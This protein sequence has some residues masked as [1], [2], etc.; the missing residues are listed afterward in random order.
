MS[1]TED[2]S[3]K[4]EEPTDK[5]IRDARKKGDV[6]S[7]KETGNLMSIFSLFVVTALIL[8]AAA[9]QLA[10]ALS[11]VIESAGR[12]EIGEAG[13]GLDEAGRVMRGLGLPLAMI[14]APAFAVMVALAIF[15][16]LI[17]GEVVV[18]GERIK[19]NLSKINPLSGLKKLFSKDTLVEF[20]KNLA[21]VAVVGIIG[22]WIARDAVTAIW[23]G[24]LFAPEALPGYLQH[25]VS[26]VLIGASAFLVPLAIVDIV[27][28]RYQWRE[29]LKMSLK[30]VRDE[31]KDSEGDPLIKRKRDEVRRR[32]ARQRV[33]QAVPTASV[34]LTNPT[35]FAVA[36]RYEA[37]RDA[38]PVCV[39]K[40]TDLVAAQIRKLARENDVPLIENRPLARALHAAVEVDQTIPAEHWK[41]VAE[42]IRYVMDI[43]ARIRRAPPAGSSLRD[44]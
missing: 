30:E 36:L 5:K 15:G 7:S 16:V 23:Q 44:D 39:A 10:E 1:E 4:T 33:A 13:E 8:P 32:R 25:E 35:H 26:R 19:P 11:R 18:A 34:V 38:A 9:P 14:L 37:G 24:R 21:K 43:R 31:H 41:A 6:P 29:K 27:W 12:V 17:Q 40:G 28:R 20:A 3:S 22:V 2:K 42:I